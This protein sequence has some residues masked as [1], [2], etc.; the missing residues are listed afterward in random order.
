MPILFPWKLPLPSGCRQVFRGQGLAEFAIIVPIILT[1]MVAGGFIGMAMFTAHTAAEAIKEPTVRKMEM[2]KNP[3]AYSNGAIL[4]MVRS[5]KGANTL[6]GLVFV[7]VP[8]ADG[9]RTKILVGTKNF[10]VALPFMPPMTFE[11][12]ATQGIQAALLAANNGSAADPSYVPGGRQPPPSQSEDP[13]GWTRTPRACQTTPIGEPEVLNLRPNNSF[14]MARNPQSFGSVFTTSLEVLELATNFAGECADG[15]GGAAATC[16]GY[17]QQL[18]PE[19]PFCKPETGGRFNY[20]P[21]TPS[22]WVEYTCKNP[23]GAPGKEMTIRMI[24]STPDKDSDTP[25]CGTTQDGPPR[26]VEVVGPP[27]GLFNDSGETS[28]EPPAE[29][30]PECVKR[31]VAECQIQRAVGMAN[32]LSAFTNRACG[33]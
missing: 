3:G 18:M 14:Y 30:V 1:I 32:A 2:A 22:S 15:G 10:T 33:N 31:K 4:S 23:P 17:R 13:Y 24:C 16:E 8:S 7:D 19:P 5:A 27:V 12:T 21:V 11:F 29:Y 25:Q 6:Q 26:F 28:G 20:D 9:S